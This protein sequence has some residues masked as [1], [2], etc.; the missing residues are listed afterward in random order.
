MGWDMAWMMNDRLK[1]DSAAGAGG[2]LV[3]YLMLALALLIA[4]SAAGSRAS[5]AGDYSVSM[6]DS[7]GGRLVRIGLNKSIVIKLP[8]EA[9]D[10]LIGNP[11]IV[12]AVIRT[13]NTAYLFARAI[14]Q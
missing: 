2:R 14:G 11:D 7:D 12:D 1:Y 13:R 5:L 6:L 8:G 4:L 9:R 10:V 3:A